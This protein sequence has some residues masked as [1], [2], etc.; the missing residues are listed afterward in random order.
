MITVR[1]GRMALRWSAR[2]AACDDRRV[3]D[4][5]GRLLGTVLSYNDA[6]GFG[7]IRGEDDRDYF[8]RFTHIVGD[9]FRTL[10]VDEH[11]VFRPEE[12]ESEQ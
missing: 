6:R 12:T 11:V 9:G 5:R 7:W 1:S 10:A 8:V 2:D 3:A 4:A